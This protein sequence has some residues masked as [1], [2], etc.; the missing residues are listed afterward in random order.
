MIRLQGIDD[1]NLAKQGALICG[2]SLCGVLR[3]RKS[4]VSR[5]LSISLATINFSLFVS[6]LLEA[7]D[8]GRKPSYPY[9][10]GSS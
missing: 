3:A 2:A 9:G 6:H 5:R 8:G 7:T 10:I 4:A 1:E